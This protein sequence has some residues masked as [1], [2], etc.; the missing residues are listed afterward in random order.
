MKIPS[1]QILRVHLVAYGGGRQKIGSNGVVKV[2]MLIKG[3]GK[4]MAFL[5]CGPFYSNLYSHKD[6]AR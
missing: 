3:G 5:K 2:S 1:N 6:P 4:I